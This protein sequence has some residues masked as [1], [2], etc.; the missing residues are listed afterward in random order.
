MQCRAELFEEETKEINYYR[1]RRFIKFA[2]RT[3]DYIATLIIFFL[4][5]NYF[6]YSTSDDWDQEINEENTVL[7]MFSLIGICFTLLFNMVLKRIILH[8]CCDGNITGSYSE[9]YDSDEDD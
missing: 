7:F 6:F 4:I 8:V 1:R 9:F 3:L 5:I 2:N